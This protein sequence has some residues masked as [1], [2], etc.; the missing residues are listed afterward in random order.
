LPDVPTVAEAAIPGFEFDLW[1]GMF[2][3][4]KTPRPIVNKY[5]AEVARILS[6]PEISKLMNTQGIVPKSSTPEQFDRFVRA[7]V[8]KLGKVIKAAG[9]KVD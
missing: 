9:I 3:P 6:L 5:A 8:E 7:E 1:Y 4:A 2:A